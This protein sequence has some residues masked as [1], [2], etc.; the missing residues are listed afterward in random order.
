MDK[1]SITFGETEL[2]KRKFHQHKNPIFIYYV[3]INKILV[4]NKVSFGKN[5]FKYFIS[6]KDD[7]KV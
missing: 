7:K 3:E 1:K 6:Y 4:S 2:K 5:C